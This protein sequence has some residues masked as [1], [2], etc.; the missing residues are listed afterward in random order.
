MKTG[1]KYGVKDFDEVKR[2]L[3]AGERIINSGYTNAGNPRWLL[4]GVMLSPELIT[5]LKSITRIQTDPKDRSR[6]Y[7]VLVTPEWIAEQERSRADDARKREEWEQS[8]ERNAVARL[9]RWR[10]RV[11]SA[12]DDAALDDVLRGIDHESAGLA[13]LGDDA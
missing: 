3:E 13:S 9:A 6:S 11:R 12:T 5:S 7:Y 1:K 10:E 8:R 4:D 2:R